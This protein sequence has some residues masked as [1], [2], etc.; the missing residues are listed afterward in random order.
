MDLYEDDNLRFSPEDGF[1][2]YLINVY[3]QFVAY[4]DVKID[5]LF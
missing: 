3:I 4:H 2:L 1:S 5:T